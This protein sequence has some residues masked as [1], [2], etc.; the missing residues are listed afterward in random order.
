MSLSFWLVRDVP[1]DFSFRLHPNLGLDIFDD[2]FLARSLRKVVIASGQTDGNNQD[3]QEAN[4]LTESDHRH[5]TSPGQQ[6]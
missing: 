1:D 2:L 3:L 6:D 4:G 5:R